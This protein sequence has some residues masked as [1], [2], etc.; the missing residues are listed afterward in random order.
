[1]KKTMKL[2]IPV[3]MAIAVAVAVP[4]LRST[5]VCSCHAPMVV[6]GSILGCSQSKQPEPESNAAV[7]NTDDAA[8]GAD[9]S[10]GKN[11]GPVEH[12]VTFVEIGSVNCIPCKMMQPIMREIER[13]FQGQVRVVFHDV[14]TPAGKPE[15]MKYGIQAIPTQVFLDK[16]GKE[17]FRHIGFFPKEELVKILKMKGVE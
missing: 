1:M 7:V 4:Y 2:I 13:E 3:V 5:G 10:A 9:A 6:F 14:W 8:S 17:Y 15:A 11:T 12:K 16:D